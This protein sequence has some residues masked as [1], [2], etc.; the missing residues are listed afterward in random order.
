[1]RIVRTIVA[2][3]LVFGV[4]CCISGTGYSQ[5]TNLGTLRGTVTDPNGATL[6][7]ALRGAFPD[8]LPLTPAVSSDTPATI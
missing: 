2:S 1:M 3:A 4:I 5:G 8:W 6:P 7:G